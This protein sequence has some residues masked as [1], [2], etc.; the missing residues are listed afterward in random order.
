MK[1]TDERVNE[2]LERTRAREAAARRTRQRAASIG[3]GALAVVIVAT[4]GIGMSSL[5]GA[6]ATSTGATLGLMGSVFASGSALGYVVVG[7]LGLALGAAVTALAHRLGRA[8]RTEGEISVHM[9]PEHA[10]QLAKDQFA[11]KPL[12]NVYTNSPECPNSDRPIDAK[13]AYDEEGRKP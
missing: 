1:S 6:G 11:N 10:N 5:P 7:L 4:I 3:G 12:E 2:V 8:P 9:S 13:A